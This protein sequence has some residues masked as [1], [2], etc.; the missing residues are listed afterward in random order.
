MRQ[1]RSQQ[2]LSK[3]FERTIK[4]FF[5]WSSLFPHRKFSTLLFG[6]LVPSNRP[7]NGYTYISGASFKSLFVSRNQKLYEKFLSV[8]RWG[9]HWYFF[10]FKSSPH[11]ST[12]YANNHLLANPWVYIVLLIYTGIF[13][14]YLAFFSSHTSPSTCH[15]IPHVPGPNLCISLPAFRSFPLSL[16][17]QHFL[18]FFSISSSYSLD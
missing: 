7:I 12:T 2:H 3:T 10:K 14:K 17:L 11:L 1:F 15:T 16:F 4:I 18:S 9:F 5:I 13:F 8:I 6:P